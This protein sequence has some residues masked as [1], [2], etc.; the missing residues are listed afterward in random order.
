[1]EILGGMRGQPGGNDAFGF[2]T[3]IGTRAM[4][5]GVPIYSFYRDDTSDPPVKYYP[6]GEMADVRQV[7]MR[8]WT[9]AEQVSHGGDTWVVFP[10]RK[11]ADSDSDS[12]GS[13]SGW[14]GAMY[15]VVT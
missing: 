5:P 6:L 7:L 4:L 13:K 10:M 12:G 8:D 11:V 2:Y 14:L 3:G 1:V 15:K 9:A